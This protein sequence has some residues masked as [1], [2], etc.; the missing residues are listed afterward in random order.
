MK[1][2]DEW[3]YLPRITENR[4]KTTSKQSMVPIKKSNEKAQ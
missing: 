4:S 3:I 2:E 1:T